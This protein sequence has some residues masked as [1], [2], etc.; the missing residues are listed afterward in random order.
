MKICVSCAKS[1]VPCLSNHQKRC[2]ECIEKSE[3]LKLQEREIRKVTKLP[4][5]NICHECGKPFGAKSGAIRLCRL[6]FGKKLSQ[7][8]KARETRLYREV[9]CECGRKFRTFS[10]H[11]KWCIDC[12][13]KKRDAAKQPSRRFIAAEKPENISK[14]IMISSIS[15]DPENLKFRKFIEKQNRIAERWNKKYKNHHTKIDN[16]P[17]MFTSVYNG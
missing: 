15:E 4:F 17:N 8:A 3:L 10:Y 13:K 1:F 9:V 12:Q 16:N 2:L 14:N 5:I 11:R 7:K 6:C